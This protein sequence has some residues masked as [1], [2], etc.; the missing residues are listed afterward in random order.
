MKRTGLS[1]ARV[2]KANDAKRQ[3]DGSV[4]REDNKVVKPEGWTPPFHGDLL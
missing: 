3:P 1:L 4:K 2:V